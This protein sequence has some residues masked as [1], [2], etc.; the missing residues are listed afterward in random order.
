MFKTKKVASSVVHLPLYMP[1]DRIL[2]VPTK[3]LLQVKQIASS[4]LST[5]KNQI[6]HSEYLKMSTCSCC[7]TEKSIDF[8]FFVAMALF[9]FAIA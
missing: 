3:T 7:V 6:T 1:N 9:R 5:Q 2:D 8:F 4:Q